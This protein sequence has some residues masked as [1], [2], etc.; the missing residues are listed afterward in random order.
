MFVFIIILLFILVLIYYYLLVSLLGANYVNNMISENLKNIVEYFKKYIQMKNLTEIID[1]VISEALE[2]LDEKARSKAQRRL[3]GMALA[4][5]RGKL[6]DRFVSDDIKNMADSMDEETL[7]EFA[8]TNEKKRRK[9]GS[10]G[11][12]SA[13]PNYTRDGRNYKENPDKK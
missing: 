1:P 9:D 13:I 8:S 10:V 12:R 5:K 11:K 3:F 4:Y 6:A 7:R 2:N